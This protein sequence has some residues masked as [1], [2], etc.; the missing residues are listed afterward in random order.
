[1]K[2]WQLLT[3]ARLHYHLCK[4]RKNPKVH[5]GAPLF[6][7]CENLHTKFVIG[8]GLPLY[9]NSL[10]F[11]LI[12]SVL[13]FLGAHFALDSDSQSL[14]NYSGVSSSPLQFHGVP[15]Y[16]SAEGTSDASICSWAMDDHGLTRFNVDTTAQG[17]MRRLSTSVLFLW[18]AAMLIMLAHAW[19]Q[20]KHAKWFESQH[21]TM[22]DLTCS[23]RATL[24]LVRE[25]RQKP[26]CIPTAGASK[27]LREPCSEDFALVLRLD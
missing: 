22:K 7:I 21:L 17:F 24:Q 20:L 13:L 10:V 23:C 26:H 14:F 27:T 12:L 6:S 3:F 19:F 15:L 9:Y 4:V 25:E 8:V 16:P 5:A 1:M 2:H 18:F 11:L